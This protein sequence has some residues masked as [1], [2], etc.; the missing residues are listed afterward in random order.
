MGITHIPIS[1]QKFKPPNAGKFCY[2]IRMVNPLF[3]RLRGY[4][5]GLN[6]LPLSEDTSG[7]SRQAK[8]GRHEEGKQA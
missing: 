2:A 5:A 7:P 6:L 3:R 4:D 1:P 8:E